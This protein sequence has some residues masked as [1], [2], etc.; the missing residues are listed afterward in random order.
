MKPLSLQLLHLQAVLSPYAKPFSLFNLRSVA[1]L[2]AVAVLPGFLV[3]SSNVNGQHA[4]GRQIA[5]ATS[6]KW[7][8]QRGVNR[9]R[10]QIARDGKFRDVLFDGLI[11]GERYVISGLA[12]GY[13]YW[14][15]APANI[16]TR[17]FL[18]PVRFFVSGGVV[19]SG[20]VGHTTGRSSPA[21]PQ[22]QAD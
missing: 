12:P 21:T 13:Y 8:K 4:T 19:T 10:L 16:Q 5:F 18:Q 22:F 14:R 11:T 3:L 17:K 2:L 7:P 6:I 9:Y 15:V 20:K 1:L